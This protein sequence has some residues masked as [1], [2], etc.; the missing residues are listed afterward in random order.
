[1]PR[2]PF[3]HGG[4]TIWDWLLS[5]PRF[6]QALAIRAV[7][8][9]GSFGHQRLLRLPVTSRPTPQSWLSQ[10][11]TPSAPPTPKPLQLASRGSQK[12][13]ANWLYEICIYHQ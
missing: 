10:M 12:A 8:A 2:Q 1:M 5:L 11:D 3:P 6:Q 13:G 4:A 7:S 9:R